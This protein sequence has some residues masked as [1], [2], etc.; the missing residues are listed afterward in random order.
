MVAHESKSNEFA[1]EE[2]KTGSMEINEKLVAYQVTN[3]ILK[4]RISKLLATDNINE[5]ANRLG[6]FNDNKT[7]D[8]KNITDK[9][10]TALKRIS[11]PSFD[12]TVFP[13]S[14]IAKITTKKQEQ[15]Q[16]LLPKID[17]KEMDFKDITI[18]H[19]IKHIVMDADDKRVQKIKTV[20]NKAKAIEN[21]R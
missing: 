17:L 14:D 7:V 2:L 19:T 1:A 8:I 11:P 10:L 18:Q 21:Q 5:A 6:V 4:E 13:K 12:E 20:R 3:S 16:K 9:Q 15:K